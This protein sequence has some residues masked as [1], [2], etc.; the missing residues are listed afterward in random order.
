MR[1]RSNVRAGAGAEIAEQKTSTGFVRKA[2]SG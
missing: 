2:I 1:V